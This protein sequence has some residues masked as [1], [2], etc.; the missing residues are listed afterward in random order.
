MGGLEKLVILSGHG[1]GTQKEW[2]KPERTKES[3]NICELSKCVFLC[4]DFVYS[5]G[6]QTTE[7]KSLVEYIK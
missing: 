3:I 4:Y 2:E 1:R 6:Y 5:S 7:S